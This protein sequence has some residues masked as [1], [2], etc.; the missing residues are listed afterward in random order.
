MFVVIKRL[1]C[2]NDTNMQLRFHYNR[3]YINRYSNS[4]CITDRRKIMTLHNPPKTSKCKM[5]SYDIKTAIMTASLIL[6]KNQYSQI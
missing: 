1:S 4:A 2:G 6:L 3:Y 5:A